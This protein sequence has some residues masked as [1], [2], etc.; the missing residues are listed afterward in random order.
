[1]KMY[2][3]KKQKE[4]F[5]LYDELNHT[6]MDLKWRQVELTKKDWK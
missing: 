4:I 5:R 1:M 6:I 2:L 3:R